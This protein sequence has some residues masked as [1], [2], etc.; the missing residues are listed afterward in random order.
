MTIGCAAPKKAERPTNANTHV[1]PHGHAG[2]LSVSVRKSA[3]LSSMAS[4]GLADLSLLHSASPLKRDAHSL[5]EES[6]NMDVSEVIEMKSES[7]Q[8]QQVQR[9]QLEREGDEH[10]I[11]DNDEDENN[12]EIS[13]IEGVTDSPH[14]TSMLLPDLSIIASAQ[15]SP[16]ANA[17]ASLSHNVHSLSKSHNTLLM[18]PPASSSSLSG[19]FGFTPYLNMLEQSFGSVDSKLSLSLSMIL[20][21]NHDKSSNGHHNMD[22]SAATAVEMS[23][24]A[25]KDVSLKRKLLDSSPAQDAMSMMISD[26]QTPARNRLSIRYF[27]SFQCMVGL[28]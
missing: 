11:E 28:L 5:A 12:V 26:V 14:S 3:R 1:Y 8:E 13:R 17:H 21:S 10:G 25:E 23:F 2:L 24:I 18:S 6:D 7:A 9:Q 22:E 4:R 19:D 27:L 20:N 16:L 15:T